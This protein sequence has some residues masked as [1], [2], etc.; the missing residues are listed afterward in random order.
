MPNVKHNTENNMKIAIVGSGISG[1][2]SAWQLSK[3][4]QVT[5]FEKNHYFG[6]HTD[7][8]QFQ[9]SGQST[10]VD[11]GFIVFNH[12][13]YPVFS[14]MLQQL[15]VASQASDMSFSVNNLHTGLQY[16][17]S[18]K[19]S[20]LAK[21]Q[22]FFNQDFRSML[23]DLMRFYA[24]NKDEMVQDY[25]ADYSIEQYLNHYGYSQAF[26]TEHLYPMCGALWSTPVAQVGQIPYKFVVSFFQ[27]H[28][29]LQVKDRPQWLTVKGGSAQYIQAIRAQC[30][31]INWQAQAVHTVRREA[32]AVL[33]E[34]EQGS[35]SFDWVIMASHA[36]DSLALLQNA[37]PIESEVLSQFSYQANRMVVHT[38]THIMPKRKSQWASWHVH[39]APDT[40]G[41]AQYG[42][43][44]WMNRLQKLRCKEQILATLNPPIAIDPSKILVE[45]HYHHPVFNAEAIAAQQRWGDINALD[46]ISYCGAYWGWGFHE[47][48]ALSAKRVVDALLAHG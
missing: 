6:G 3:Q 48:G 16:N 25:A 26:R 34:T 19:W 31:Q 5:L 44:Y 18:Q 40:Q 47:D 36:D 37:L 28:R 21:P 43:S 27:H 39:V 13:N 32:D 4:H 8:H 11:S 20:L 46:R 22:N 38:D 42:F 14:D 35:Q 10:A 17:P 29:M 12:H 9:L 30:P 2:Y 24:D 45:R 23:R 41:Q 15:G 33:V 7:T 1:V